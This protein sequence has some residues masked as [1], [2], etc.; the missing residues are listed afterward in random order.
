MGLGRFLACTFN[1]LFLGMSGLLLGLKWKANGGGRLPNNFLIHRLVKLAKTYYPFLLLMFVFY[2][3]FTD[4]PLTVKDV[5]MHIAFLPWFDKLHGFGHLWFM[6]MIVICYVVVYVI[7]RISCAVGKHEPHF[8][9]R[10]GGRFILI[11]CV[12][13]LI[14]PLHHLM[15]S[16]GLPGQL[17]LYL[18]FFILCFYHAVDVVTWMKKV[19]WVNVILASF[20]IG[21]SILIFRAGL[22]A[23]NRL[24]A[25]WLGVLGAIAV[26]M[27]VLRTCREN[28]TN[29]IVSFISGIS[30]E[31]YL[32]HHN[33]AFGKYSIVNCV[34]NPI[35]G[36]VA[37]FMFSFFAAF[38]LKKLS[39][40]VTVILKRRD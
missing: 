26:A 25:E 1:A 38:V 21:C 16:Y 40:V 15:L 14:F 29:K 34:G 22:Y 36:L 32:V 17:L 30:F 19:N 31:I 6:T 23:S 24:L 13:V 39:E 8:T 33:F 35:V 20:I 18:W 37:L 5:V 10:G 2:G 3:V 11:L 4:Y 7:S 28:Y 12:T 27:I 9:C